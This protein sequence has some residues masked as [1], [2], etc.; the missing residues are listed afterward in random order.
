MKTYQIL[1]NF[2]T[3][4]IYFFISPSTEEEI[5][6]LMDSLNLKKAIR[7]V[8]VKTKFPKFDRVLIFD[9]LSKIFNKFIEEGMYPSCLKIIAEVIP[10][11]KNYQL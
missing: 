11:F 8:D 4:Q 5:R 6:S 10:I 9:K 2:K 1:F 7:E 3:Q